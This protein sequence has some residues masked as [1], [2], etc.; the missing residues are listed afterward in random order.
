MMGSNQQGFWEKRKES[1]EAV[2]EASSLKVDAAH[3][4]LGESCR[5][6]SRRKAEGVLASWVQGAPVA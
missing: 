1:L 6:R 5:K 2:S 4:D 3:L